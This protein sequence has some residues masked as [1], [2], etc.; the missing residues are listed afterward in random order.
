MH[1]HNSYSPGSN[2]HSGQSYF[3]V[4]SSRGQ[5]VPPNAVICGKDK[6]GSDIYV[7]LAHYSGDE[8]PAKVV[9]RRREAYVSYDGKEISVAEYKLLVEKKLKWIPST[10]GRIPPG[11]VPAGRTSTGE[12]LYV[13]RRLVEGNVMAVGKVHYSHGCIY[14]PFGGREISYREYEILV[15]E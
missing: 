3:W 8:L 12:T 4:N 5:P 10:G 2:S 6:D 1:R 14:I 13:G 11:A 9:P 7:G 15:Y